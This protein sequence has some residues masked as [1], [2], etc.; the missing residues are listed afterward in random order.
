MKRKIR[1]WIYGIG[2]FLLLGGNLKAEP[3]KLY[4]DGKMHHYQLPPITLYMNGEALKTETMP[5]VQLDDRVLV[6]AKEVFE[7][8]G[9][10]VEWD[11]IQK[12]VYIYRENK[13][14]IL[15]MDSTEA[16]VDGESYALD[17]PPKNINDKMMIPLRF[18][19]EAMGC[20]VIWENESRCV[21]ILVQEEQVPVKPPDF[22]EGIDLPEEVFPLDPLPTYSVPE[23]GET[24]F[25][26]GILEGIEYFPGKGSFSIN[27]PQ[28]LLVD[29]L[30]LTDKYNERRWVVDF[31]GDYS[32]VLKNGTYEGTYGPLKKLTIQTDLTTRMVIDTYTV[33]A[34][35]VYGMNGKLQFDLEAPNKK[36]GK[37][38]V[39]DPGHG[40][41]QPGTSGG[42]VVEKN[43]NLQYGMDFFRLLD[44]DPDI[45]VYI[46]RQEDIDVG[47]EERAQLANEIMPDLFISIHSNA[48]TGSSQRQETIKGTETYYFDNPNDLRDKKFAERVQKNIVTTFN[49]NNRGAKPDTGYEV[50]RK[51]TMPGVLIEVGFLTN[52]E[53]RAK[54]TQ[55]DFSQRLAQVLYE[56]VKSYYEEDVTY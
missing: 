25:P 24:S 1:R 31:Q 5:A 46:T 45:K 4:Y 47:R 15:K 50:L 22:I 8:M 14:I 20:D 13:L 27:K 30:V 21:Y 39:I 56:S 41:S 54:M 16:W 51:V 3:L 35:T 49:M 19:S 42:G 23:G 17:V 32:S 28:Q 26:L 9:A 12:S 52:S 2:L 37:L 11:P 36:Y 10:I 40:G 48:I 55:P 43:L 34:L 53:D 7:Q 33:Q 44:E 38:I 18:M 6:P 29:N